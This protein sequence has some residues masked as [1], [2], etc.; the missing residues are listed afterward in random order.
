[1]PQCARLR[2]GGTE[3]ISCLRAPA[4][5]RRI[6]Y[7][8]PDSDAAETFYVSSCDQLRAAIPLPCWGRL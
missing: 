3:G 5:R 1:M 8:L 4:R 7:S 2:A 6:G